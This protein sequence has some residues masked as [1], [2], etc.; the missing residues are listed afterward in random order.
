MKQG[1]EMKYM[2][3]KE[4]I[5][6][7]YKGHKL[8]VW[9]G[10]GLITG[11]IAAAVIFLPKSS[12]A[13]AEENVQYVEVIRGSITESFGEVGYVKA[14]PSASLSWETD[15]VIADYEIQVGDV[16][17]K[18]DV[19]MELE[20]SSWP[21]TSLEAIDDLLAAE[22]ALE[23]MITSE[24]ELQIAL[25]GVVDAELIVKSKR[26]MVD[27]WNFAQSPIERVMDAREYYLTALRN[28]WA[29][30][31]AYEDLRL[32][33]EEDDPDL[34]AAYD[35]MQEADLVRDKQLRALNQI[36]GHSYDHDVETDFIEWDTAKG[37]FE[38][39]RVNYEKFLDESQEV[40]AQEATVQSLQNTVNE[41]RI[42]APF[43]G[44]VTEISYLPGEYVASGSIAVQV[45]D[46]HNMVVNI[47]VS[48]IDVIEVAVGD[49]VVVT[50]D[51][52][53]FREYDAVVSSIASAGSDSSGS[54]TF[55]V[56]VTL[57]NA[58]EDIKPGFTADVS[59][60]TS[61]AIEAL[62]VPSQALLGRA[63]NFR[64]MVIGE[65][66]IPTPVQ[67]E[68][69]AS[70][71]TYTEIINGDIAEGD[72][73]IVSLNSGAPSDEQMETMRMMREL[74]GGGDGPPPGG[75]KDGARNNP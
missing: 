48:E 61:Q 13:L 38:V 59:I 17:Q 18:G 31:E 5:L 20:L 3:M 68:I 30:D 23:N 36:L 60:I 34:V 46:L 32:V 49:P 70:S 41:A 12:T 26:E 67:V 27:F 56:T 73:L 14:E 66:G 16:V 21:N 74:N 39:A 64:V 53:P 42:I 65:D 45:D 40:S 19:L 33:L 37:N 8:L 1:D 54:V 2:N 75:G 71:E 35:A 29:T 7:F 6:R 51:A 63:G 47:T 69:G 24:S 10:A 25:Q 43:D 11:V 58:D 50:F 22:L 4:K 28:Y 55:D 57:T 44:T 15:G 62:L 9:V 52:L 72:Q